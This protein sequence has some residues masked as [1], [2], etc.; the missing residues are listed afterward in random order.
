MAE[1]NVIVTDEEGTV[2]F[3]EHVE[4]QEDDPAVTG[5]QKRE[6]RSAVVEAANQIRGGLL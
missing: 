5:S 2:V 4:V 3:S 6:A 1:Y